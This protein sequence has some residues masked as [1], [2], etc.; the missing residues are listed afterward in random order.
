[1]N[2]ELLHYYNRE[3]AYLRELGAEFAQAYPKVAARLGVH[4]T[5]VAD[6]YVERLL[7]GFSFLTARIQM[8]MDA[9]FPR[10][11]QQLLDVI[12]PSWLMPTPS[13]GL[14]QFRPSMSEG[15]LAK[16]FTL[17][18]H[19]ALRSRI[20]AGEQTAC[21]FS[22]CHAV[23]LWPMSL[24]QVRLGDM[25]ADLPLAALGSRQAAQARSALK[26][27]FTVQ[28][29]LTLEELALDEL[30]LHLDGPESDSSLLLDALLRQAL[31]VFI[32]MEDEAPQF[33]A[34][35]DC[36]THDGLEDE[37]A[38]LPMVSH[39]FS[40]HRLLREYFALPDRFAFVRLRGLQAAIARGR[41]QE[42][43]SRRWSLHIVLKQVWPDLAA[44]VGPGHVRL[45]CTPVVNLFRRRS[46]RMALR[47]QA[48]DHHV[49]MDR[50]RPMDFE[51]CL[52]EQVQ[53]HSRQGSDDV[54]FRPLYA[55][56]A[57]DAGRYGSYYTLRREPRVVSD[58]QKRWGGRSSYGGSEVYLSLVN[59]HE[60]SEFFGMNQISVTAW[61][62]NRDLPLLLPRSP[63]SDFSLQV[64][65]PV[66][67]VSLLGALTRPRA[68]STGGRQAWDLISQ[69]SLAQLGVAQSD[70]TQA[71]GRWRTLLAPHVDSS[72]AGALRQL[73]SIMSVQARPVQRAMP[74]PGPLV[75]ARG[76]HFEVTLDQSGFPGGRPFVLAAVLSRYLARHVSL[77][78]FVSTQ[79]LSETG[80]ELGAW[81]PQAG[82]R[83]VL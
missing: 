27:D 54:L 62:S 47:P 18:R 65:A 35:S 17:P 11:S 20:P 78:S 57:Q 53:G 50:T 5:A 82:T 7:E 19:T 59:Q 40:G 68:A 64:S 15:A 9:E 13:M 44:R 21:E 39:E 77:N 60:Q 79:F 73:A 71:A 45:Y 41:A 70:P 14:V 8:K 1:M 49:V 22:T 74:G 4:D 66:A 58:T 43:K 23:D 30:S 29:G 76:V 33:L 37:Q 80:V 46:E 56:T 38:I 61:C 36:L 81:G 25:A 12:Q 26:L 48:T 42:R 34:T 55:S 51:V 52:M 31:G 83:A 69:M 10:L 6:P 67:G 72:D 75:M 16:G 32:Q 2:P 63:E 28:G 24:S 3:L